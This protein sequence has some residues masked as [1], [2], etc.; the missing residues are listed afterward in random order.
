MHI[1]MKVIVKAW[2]RYHEVVTI[3]MLS[4]YSQSVLV[5]Q[6]CSRSFYFN[7]CVFIVNFYC[8][9]LSPIMS[10]FIYI[11]LGGSDEGVFDK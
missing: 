11:S 5:L 6:E 7:T 9:D 4:L 1:I 10:W 3:K 8:V 2:L